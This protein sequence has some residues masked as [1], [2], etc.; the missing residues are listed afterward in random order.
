MNCEAALAH[1]D[2][3]IDGQLAAGERS[4][5]EE[6]MRGCD[7]CRAELERARS[8][9]ARAKALPRSVNPPPE[10][11][12]A[13]RSRITSAPAV[14]RIGSRSRPGLPTPFLIAAGI[15]LMLLSS[16]LTALWMRRAAPDREF[17]VAQTE[18]V[19]ATADLAHRLEGNPRGLAPT[20]LAV[21]E[22]N[23]TIVDAAI[24]EAEEA[25]ENDPGDASLQRMLLA[26]YQQRLE[27]LQRA[28]RAGQ[29]S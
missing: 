2:D 28:A 15:A 4:A 12:A 24:H 20:T 23:L 14:A 9:V 13:I 7:G 1:L 29:E 6:H 21:L 27:L 26:R 19:R 17:A 10:V 3:Y 5:L 25:L 22:R 11:W 16:A 8:L 18:Y